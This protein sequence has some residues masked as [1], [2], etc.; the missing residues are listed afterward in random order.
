M[1][2]VGWYFMFFKITDG[3]DYLYVGFNKYSNNLK[4]FSINE[5]AYSVICRMR[6]PELGSGIRMAYI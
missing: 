2:T 3:L 6:Y 5:A 1:D 4:L